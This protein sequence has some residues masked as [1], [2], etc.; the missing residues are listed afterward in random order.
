MKYYIPIYLFA[1]LAF[2]TTYA[3]KVTAQEVPALIVQTAEQPPQ[4]SLD[5]QDS[6]IVI[7]R[8]YA[9]PTAWPTTIKIDGTK[10]VSLA[11]RQYSHKKLTPGKHKV[12]LNWA[13]LSGQINS[14]IEIEIIEGETLFLAVQGISQFAGFGYQSYI[15]NMGSNF[16]KI[17]NEK[18]PEIIQKCCRFKL[19][20]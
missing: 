6:N 3:S 16:S 20:D 4:I 12:S 15:F 10:L 7:V 2:S 1:F 13:F 14:E 11:N 19:A 8:E 17:D 9:Q 18:A 5:I